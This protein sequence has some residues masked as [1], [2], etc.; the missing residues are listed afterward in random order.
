[1]TAIT[2]GEPYYIGI[3]KSIYQSF[4]DHGGEGN[5]VSILSDAIKALRQ[6]GPKGLDL[7]VRL[8]SKRKFL[9]VPLLREDSPFRPEEEDFDKT[10][11]SLEETRKI[12]CLSHNNI[13]RISSKNNIRQIIKCPSIFLV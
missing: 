10:W 12:L 5:F 1:M 2:F 6:K 9:L 4:L 11:T 3:G 7:W 8:D 13:C